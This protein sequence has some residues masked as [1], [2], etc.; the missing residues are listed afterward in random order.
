ME[1]GSLV[2]FVDASHVHDLEFPSPTGVG[3]YR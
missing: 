1:S 2:I 3:S